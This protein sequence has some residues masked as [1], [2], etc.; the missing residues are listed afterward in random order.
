MRSVT[1]ASLAALMIGQINAHPAIWNPPPKADG[2]PIPGRGLQ[3]HSHAKR[4]GANWNDFRFKTSSTYVNTRGTRGNSSIALTKRGTAEDTATELVKSTVPGATFRLVET[5]V[6][7]NGVSHI[8]FKQTAN[9]MDIDNADFNVNVG[10]NGEVFSYG[11]S[12][13]TGAVPASR[14]RKRDMIDPSDAL[15]GA[16]EVLGLPLTPADSATAQAT[17]GSDEAY[18]ISDVDGMPG[19]PQTKLVYIQ[20][21]DGKLVPTW[22]VETDL[23]DNWLLTY[24]DVTD[25]S[26]IHGLV[27]YRADATYQVYPW[28]VNDPTEGERIIVEDP[29][30]PDASEFGWHSTGDDDYTDTRGNNGFAQIN[31]E[32]D[33]DYLND[34]RPSNPDL[35]FVYP[36]SLNETDPKAYGNASVTQLFYTANTYHDLLYI[37]GFTEA[38]G[39]F[40]I[41]NDDE[42]GEGNDMVILQA[43]DGSGTDNA[44][45]LTPP[46]GES[47]RMAMFLWEYA[48]PVRDC[49]FEAGV[50]IHEYTHGLSTRLTGG[51]A[52]SNCLDGP[53]D[54]SMGEG[55]GDFMATAI[56]LKP[57]DTR[58]TDYALGAWVGN[59][60]KGIRQYLYST[61]METNPYVYTDVD[62]L[63]AEPHDAGTVWATV[64]Y[65]VLWNL[66]DK[67]GKNDAAVPDFDDNGVPTDG[68]YL[69]MKL[70]MDGMALQ[71]C[72]PNFVSGRDAIID[73]DDALTGGD[74]YCELWTAFAKRGLGDGAQFSETNRTASFDLPS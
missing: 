12:F 74:N 60:P 48:Q 22:R 47:G 3:E 1:V 55:W 38:A 51:P 5:R 28:G 20:S 56:R 32:G 35:D 10:K 44:W 31:A 24:V 50:V 23:L 33:D 68:K 57:A 18:S 30:N 27:N 39:N 67:H 59:D 8:Y 6:G 62:E 4:S 53:E 73:A 66:I 2:R 15:K 52:N 46:D 65:E 70:V 19:D 34:P 26:Q 36:F 72:N 11:N 71:P 42:G 58:E 14:L 49:S 61:N 16:I 64:L 21:A 29:W 40:E 45:F 69:A 41:N 7:D 37:L 63:V 17:E 43:Q 54:S 13:Y 25:G 9:G